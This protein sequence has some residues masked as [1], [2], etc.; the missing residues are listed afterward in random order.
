MTSRR[1]NAAHQ[2]PDDKFHEQMR[3]N[4]RM[5]RQS[6]NLHATRLTLSAGT[7]YQWENHNLS[8]AKLGDLIVLARDY[9]FTPEEF[10]GFLFRDSPMSSTPEEHSRQRVSAYMMSL[11]AEESEQ[12]ADI[13]HAVVQT[14]RRSSS[15]EATHEE[16]L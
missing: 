2:I 1:T 11:D 8:T 13:V 12:C 9:G 4:L 14:L 15:S 3:E 6:R 5:M 10:F 7:L 16:G